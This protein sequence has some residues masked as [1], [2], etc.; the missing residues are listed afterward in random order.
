MGIWRNLLA[1]PLTVVGC[2]LFGLAVIDWLDYP[3]VISYH[4]VER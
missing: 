1:V 2:T 3:W 4:A